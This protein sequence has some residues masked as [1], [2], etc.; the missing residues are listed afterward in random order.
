MQA[1]CFCKQIESTDHPYPAE[2]NLS[3]SPPSRYL[4]AFKADNHFISSCGRKKSLHTSV[5]IDP[6]NVCKHRKPRLGARAAWGQK[7]G[8]ANRPAYYVK[9]KQT[10]LIDR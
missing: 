10:S 4:S 9:E 8:A 1:W 2:R 3:S 7:N 6:F 5:P